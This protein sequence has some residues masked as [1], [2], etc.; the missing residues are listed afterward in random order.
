MMIEYQ[1][2]SNLINSIHIVMMGV[3]AEA[4]QLSY[5]NNSKDILYKDFKLYYYIW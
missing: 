1:C 5:I 2:L 3:N 4:L